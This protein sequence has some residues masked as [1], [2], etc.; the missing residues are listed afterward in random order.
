MEILAGGVGGLTNR[1]PAG[2]V[3]NAV[4]SEG[5]GNQDLVSVESLPVDNQSDKFSLFAMANLAKRFIGSKAWCLGLKRLDIGLGY[6][7]IVGVFLAEIQP[8]SAKVDEKLWI[9]VGDLPPAYLVTD[10]AANPASALE[11]YI[12]NMREWVAAVLNGRELDNLI[13]VNAAPTQSN[14]KDLDYRLDFLEREVLGR[15]RRGEADDVPRG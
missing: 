6:E 4:E 7:G 9:V 1:L 12:E 10:D 11:G 14:A 8:E 2:A 3:L 15:V 13:P 5:M